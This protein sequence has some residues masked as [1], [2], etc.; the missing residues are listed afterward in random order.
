MRTRL[1]SSVVCLVTLCVTL[2]SLTGCGRPDP[3]ST[4]VVP[5]PPKEGTVWTL[6]LTGGEKGVAEQT[7]IFNAFVE[8]IT[9]NPDDGYPAWKLPEGWTETSPGN[10]LTLLQ[11][12]TTPRLTIEVRPVDAL[13]PVRNLQ[14]QEI[15]N[16]QR[17]VV[18]LSDV[19]QATASGGLDGGYGANSQTS[20]AT[21]KTG[22]KSEI[23]GRAA[24]G[25][26]DSND[27]ARQ[28]FPTATKSGELAEWPLGEYS[29]YRVKLKGE[30]NQFGN[31]L[32]IGAIIPVPLQRSDLPF[33]F[34]APAHWT[35]GAQTQF[36]ILSRQ[37]TDAEGRTASITV[38]PAMGGMLPNINRWRTQAGIAP[39][40]E[41][42]Y[43]ENMEV[44][45][46][47]GVDAAYTEAVGS[48]RTILGGMIVKVDSQSPDEP[49]VYFFKLDGDPKLAEQER[50]NFKAF[51]QSVKFRR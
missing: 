4:Y 21:E 8:S 12:P 27:D 35:P 11:I 28:W 26:E 23:A 36:S 48:T 14:L 37:V 5:H 7:D 42:N 17:R 2:L 15:F 31:T 19:G 47:H 51:F 41:E 3:V 13:I 1:D 33:S 10:N 32:L 30:T 6:Q 25:N 20:D 46:I 39:L 16:R 50:D 49:S 9:F 29:G 24:S 43:L 45:M 34:K 22:P 40:T 44:T 38:S 18:K